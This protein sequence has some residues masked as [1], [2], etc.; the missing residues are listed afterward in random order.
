MKWKYEINVWEFG[1]D[2]N[3]TIE[4]CP[5]LDFWETTRHLNML[6]PW[7]VLEVILIILKL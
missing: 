4:L 3:H 6:L 5:N 1:I 2:F 7:N